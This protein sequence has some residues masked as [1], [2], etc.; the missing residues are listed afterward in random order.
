[1]VRKR[2][3]QH[4]C[5]NCDFEFSSKSEHTNYCPNCGQ[6]NHNPRH[7]LIYYGYELLES[8]L[9][10]D[11]KFFYTLKIL[12]FH[13]G[14]LT[15]DYINNIRGRYMPPFRMF[16][17]ISIFALGVVGIFENFL[18]ES[19]AFGDRGSDQR[20]DKL[21][22]GE[23]FDNSSDTLK[24]K[25]LVAPFSWIM[26]NPEVTHKQ[27]RKL[28]SS[29]EDSIGSWLVENGYSNNVLTRFYAQNKKLRVSRQ[30]TDSE[31]VPMVVNIFK[32][33]F[34]L[35]IP[36]FAFVCFVFFYRKNLL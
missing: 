27:L 6:E 12:L 5:P 15:I 18:F 20:K 11:T 8:L 3:K 34:L 14:K 29:P 23:M 21:T 35:M 32:I 10:F 26:N 28:K 22:I 31:V 4:A 13:P 33:L 25:I 24:D 2:N 16:I 7:P 19:G 36:I 1:M 30:M 17:F 9:H